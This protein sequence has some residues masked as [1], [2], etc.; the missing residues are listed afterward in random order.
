MD[1]IDNPLW[2]EKYRP[3]KIA[4]VIAPIAIKSV[5]SQYV[6]DKDVPVNLLL[7]GPPGTGKTTCAKALLTEVGAEFVVINGSLERNIDT[8]RNDV[9]QFASTLSIFGQSGRKFVILDEADYLNPNSF[10]PALRN[11]MEEYSKHCGFILTCNY[12]HKIIDPLWSRC[13]IIDFKIPSGEK[14]TLAKE[15]IARLRAILDNEEVKYDVAVLTQVVIKFFPDWRR[16][17]NELQRYSSTNKVIDTGILSNFQESTIK[18]LVGH[19]KAKEFTAVRK[20]VADNSDMDAAELYSTLYDVASTYVDPKS[21]PVL[22]MILA[23]YQYKNAF[24]V[25]PEINTCACLA[26]IMSEISFKA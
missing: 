22:I 11:F 12:K 9:K 17:L 4:D 2:V 14:Q 8:L 3:T 25:N 7:S 19:L 21:I 26:S 16:V 6:K 15:F 24:A 13:S 5:F 23:D 20:W 10:Q 18:K 1:T